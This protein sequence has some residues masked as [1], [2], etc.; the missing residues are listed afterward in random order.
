MVGSHLEQTPR[1]QANISLDHVGVSVADLEMA[2]KWYSENLGFRILKSKVH[3]KRDPQNTR[4]EDIHLFQVYPEPL[5]EAYVSFLVSGNG[6]GIELFEFVDPKHDTTLPFGPQLW[7]Q[8]GCFH[9]ALTD[10]DPIGLSKRLVQAGAKALADPV[11][12]GTK[13]LCIAYLQDPCGL[14]LEICSQGFGQGVLE[15]V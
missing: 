12:Y 8:T 2:T 13:S 9:F 6:I 5:N 3:F 1:V 11:V 10:A 4:H 7:T 14:I 15:S